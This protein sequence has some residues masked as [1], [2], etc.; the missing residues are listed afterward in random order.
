MRTREALVFKGGGQGIDTDK[1]HSGGMSRLWWEFD[2]PVASKQSLADCM[3]RGILVGLKI[4]GT[5][6]TLAD[7]MHQALND[8]GFSVMTNPNGCG[9]MFDSEQHDV[10]GM[11]T[12]LR[13]WRTLRTRRLTVLTIEPFQG[14]SLTPEFVRLVNTDPSL[15]LCVQ[16]Y[17]TVA[18]DELYP[19][20]ATAAVDDLVAAGIQRGKVTQ[21]LRGNPVPYGWEGIVFGFDSLPSTPPAAL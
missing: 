6:P 4:N 15:T 16:D 7:V 1:A 14:G 9:V 13:Y 21:F 3:G 8:H 17:V 2:D 19:A 5:G 11:V 20:M 10:P 18:D 12:M